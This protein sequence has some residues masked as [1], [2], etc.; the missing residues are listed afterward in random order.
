MTRFP[1][2]FVMSSAAVMLFLYLPVFVLMA[3]SF[4]DSQMGITWKGF[5]L[6]WYQKLLGDPSILEAT[7]NSLVIAS[8]STAVSLFLGVG[9]AIGL[10]RWH[11]RDSGLV[12]MGLIMPLVIPEILLGVA[13]VMMFVMLQVPLGF[14]TIIIGHTV[15]NLPLTIVVIRARLRKL[16]PLWQEAAR[17]LGATPWEVVRHVT[18]PLL[19]PAIIGAALL[20]FTVSLDDFVV[21]FFVSGPGS[22]TLPL[23]VF[24]LIKTGITPEINALSALLVAVS[25]ICVGLSWVY[26]QRSGWVDHTG[27]SG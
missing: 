18:L 13:L 2:I 8:A 22:T 25:M 5:S 11:G 7:L 19:K 17:D 23:K 4:N 9:T 16:D 14:L 6:R 21:T 10:E 12:T 20:N 26:Q 1:R 3:L 15:F 27:S 24:S